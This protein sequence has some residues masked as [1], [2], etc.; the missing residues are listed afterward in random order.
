MMTALCFE[1]SWVAVVSSRKNRMSAGNFQ[2]SVPLSPMP[3]RTVPFM[4]VA[5]T[6]LIERSPDLSML[7][8]RFFFI[9]MSLSDQ[10]SLQSFL[11]IKSENKNGGR[12][13]VGFYLYRLSGYFGRA[14]IV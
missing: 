7:D 9:G 3:L 10:L 12:G 4:Q 13:A 2:G 6:M 8:S 14:G 5:T 1:G 11:D